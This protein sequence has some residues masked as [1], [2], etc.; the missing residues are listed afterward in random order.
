MLKNS[1]FLGRNFVLIVKTGLI[2]DMFSAVFG[3]E[4]LI[5]PKKWPTQAMTRVCHLGFR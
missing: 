2:W 1:G 4:A 3:E 5:I